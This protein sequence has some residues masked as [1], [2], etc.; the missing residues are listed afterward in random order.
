[1]AII[2][3]VIMSIIK[4]TT[5]LILNVLMAKYLFT[6]KFTSMCIS[7]YNPIHQ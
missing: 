5:A 3:M 1:M 6:I 4:F 7:K 2:K